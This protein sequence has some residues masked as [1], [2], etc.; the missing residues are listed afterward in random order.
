[1]IQKMQK[2]PI[3]YSVSLDAMKWCGHVLTKDENF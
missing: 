3:M 1:M 2:I